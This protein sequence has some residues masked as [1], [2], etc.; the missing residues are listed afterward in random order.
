[1]TMLVVVRMAVRVVMVRVAVSMVVIGMSVPI[2]RMWVIACRRIDQSMVPMFVGLGLIVIYGGQVLVLVLVLDRSVA[3]LVGVREL[4]GH[5]GT[6]AASLTPARGIAASPLLRAR[7]QQ[8]PQVS[9][10]RQASRP[11]RTAT[12]AM[13]SPATGSAHHHPNR[14]FA[15]RP[16]SSAIE[17]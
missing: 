10:P 8:Q 13:I 9:S 17:R 2:M 3:V 15:P 16:M 1:M 14:A 5:D 4:F 6:V 11:S 12:A 7:G